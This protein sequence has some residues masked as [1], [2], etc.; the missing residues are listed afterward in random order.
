MQIRRRRGNWT[1]KWAGN[2]CSWLQFTLRV[3][4][5]EQSNLWFSSISDRIGGKRQSL[6]FH[7]RLSQFRAINQLFRGKLG[8]LKLQSLHYVLSSSPDGIKSCRG[9][10]RRDK[11]NI[12]ALSGM[13]LSK[14]VSWLFGFWYQKLHQS[15]L[16]HESLKL[17]LSPNG[18]NQIPLTSPL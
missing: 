7:G 9:E 12:W 6:L 1:A 13:K 18:I 8:Q 16:S 4:I 15:T 10:V 11:R 2:E 3:L 14:N 5:A 17:Q